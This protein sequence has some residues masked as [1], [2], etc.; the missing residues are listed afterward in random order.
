[1]QAATGTGSVVKSGLGTD[2][3]TSTENFIALE[4][5]DGE[6]GMGNAD[7]GMLYDSSSFDVRYVLYVSSMDLHSSGDD[8]N[9]VSMTD[10]LFLSFNF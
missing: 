10:G 1:M 9:I 3:V 6:I 5:V 4:D 8:R 2:A 7:T